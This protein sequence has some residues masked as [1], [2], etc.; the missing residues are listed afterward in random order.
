MNN[1]TNASCDGRVVKTC[2]NVSACV[3]ISVY[4]AFLIFFFFYIFFLHPQFSVCT[5]LVLWN[6]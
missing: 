2:G 6:S 5:R 4:M 1:Q 3:K